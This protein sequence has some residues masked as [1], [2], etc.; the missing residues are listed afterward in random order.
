MSIEPELTREHFES[1]IGTFN[2]VAALLRDGL[3]EH[4]RSEEVSREA[5]TR[6]EGEHYF[7]LDGEFNLHTLAGLLTRDLLKTFTVGKDE[8]CAT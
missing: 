5:F 7:T 6:D 8:P 1:L 3:E 4:L 2:D